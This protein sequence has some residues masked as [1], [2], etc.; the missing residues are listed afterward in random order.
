MEK[1]KNPL[2][3]IYFFGIISLLGDI[4]YEGVRSIIGPY[5]SLLGA[6]AVVIGFFSGFGEFLNY[7]LRFFSGY[8][9]DKRKIY[10]PFTI[11]GYLL[12]CLLPL[13]SF[14]KFWKLAVL[15]ILLERIGKGIRTPARDTLISFAGKD[16][17]YGRSFGIHELFDQIGA[18]IGP[19]IFLYSL[20]KF[21]NYK[22]AF[23]LLYLPSFFLILTLLFARK[24]YNPTLPKEEDL[25]VF[26]GKVSYEFL[27]YNLFVFFSIIGLLNFPIISYH[28][29]NKK[30]LEASQIP[31]FY[32]I[33]MAVDGLVAL[34]AGYLYDRIKFKTLLFIPFLTAI[35]PFFFLSLNF[36]FSILG[37]IIF[38]FIIGC[39]ETVLRAF[40]GDMIG[41]EK[42]GFAYGIFNGIYG[43][44]LFVGGWI[45][46]LLYQK[47]FKY[48]Y[49]YVIFVE[50]I[51][52]LF[53]SLQIKNLKMKGLKR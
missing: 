45:I 33:A 22:F 19:F 29:F 9:S 41:V 4:I 30:I 31:L 34:F 17:G 13:L 6:S 50:I 39:H 28:L 37:I 49:L 14:A 53:L 23:N 51:S 18:M 46:G 27:N 1:M 15:I 5:L 10:W 42:R 12:I 32:I 20:S 52:F 26:K 47:N 11:S 48:V 38:G 43:F 8:F 21:K 40:I 7:F 2:K 25:K 44:S 3:I 16:I 24:N 36:T 35:L